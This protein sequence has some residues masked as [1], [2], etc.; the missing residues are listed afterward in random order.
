MT[1]EFNSFIA[2]GVDL[3]FAGFSDAGEVLGA[4]SSAPTPG[5]VGS[6]MFRVA[7]AQSIPSTVPDAER[8]PIDGDNTNLGTFLFDSSSPNEFTI[9]RAVFDLS[10]IAAFNGTRVRTFGNWLSTAVLRSS[11]DNYADFA[12]IIQSN[13]KKKG[14]SVEGKAAWAGYFA[15]I[16]TVVPLGRESFDSRTAA[17]DR[18][19]VVANPS[20]KYPYG[21]SLSIAQNAA[22]TAPFI[23]FSSDY[24]MHIKRYTGDNATVTFN[25]D[26]TP[27]STSYILVYVDT[28][29]GSYAVAVSS[30]NVN[31]KT[32][33]LSAA[34]ATN[35]KVFAVYGFVP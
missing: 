28:G 32:F 31:N 23:P 19:S 15:P 16:T 18:L 13:V 29:I 25:L 6:G 24:P 5:A 9:N 34:P 10:Q 27:V 4:T 14:G 17:S 21:V 26:Y 11:N 12:W 35:A 7:G 30:V 22:E 20:S 8:V 2:A 3:V 33:T 1:N